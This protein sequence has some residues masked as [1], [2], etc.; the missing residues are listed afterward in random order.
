VEGQLEQSDGRWRLR[1]TRTLP[2][3]PEKVWRAITEP[4]H[5]GAW[6][7]TDIEGERRTGAPLRFVF[8]NGEGPT[9][10]G[11]MIAY[12][13][14][15][16][17]EFR[18]GSDETLRFELQ[19]DVEGS[20]LTFLNTFDE[21]GKA[22]RDAAGWHVCLDALAYHLD[23]PEAHVDGEEAPGTPGERWQQVHT[24]YVERFGPDAS[25]IGPPAGHAAV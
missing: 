22:A 4:E 5:L 13:P 19:P 16:V 7:P 21:L 1:F 8:R 12:D 14:P 23:G 6:F 25:T 2:H 18:W 11:E 10:A 3:P 17:L 9:V 24:S 15:S 20:V